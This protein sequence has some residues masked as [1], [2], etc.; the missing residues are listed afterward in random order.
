MPQ[1]VGD[2]KSALVGDAERHLKMGDIK[3][4]NSKQAVM[5]RGGT[6]GQSILS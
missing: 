2:A 6:R 1:S 5:K 4:H 3:Y